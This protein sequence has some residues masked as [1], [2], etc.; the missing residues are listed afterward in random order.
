MMKAYILTKFW[1]S[2]FIFVITGYEN[3]VSLYISMWICGFSS[4]ILVHQKSK[5]MKLLNQI[6]W[7][8]VFAIDSIRNRNEL[9]KYNS[10]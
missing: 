5:Q 7:Q 10:M 6:K 4:A 8:E 2:L 9:F 3:Q 1:V